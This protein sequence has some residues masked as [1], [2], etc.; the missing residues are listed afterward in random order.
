MGATLQTVTNI[1]KEVYSGDI[2][3]Q[4]NDD[5]T[6][7]KRIKSTSQGVTN[8]VGGRY[9]VF[10]IRTRRNQGIGARN[11]NE[12][13]PAAGQQGTAAGRVGLKYL[14][15]SIQLTGQVISLADSNYQSFASALDEEVT[16]V[17]NDVSKD[18][19]RQFY[20]D[21][22]GTLA[23]ITADGANTVTVA[24][25]QYLEEG[26]QIDIIDGTTLAAATPT[27]KASNRQITA[28]NQT[29]KVV[30]YSGADATAVANDVLVRTGNANREMTG[31]KAIIKNSGTLYN[32]DPTVEPVW[33]ANVLDN[34][35]TPR[36]LSEALMVQAVDAVR[37]KGS[38]VTVGFTSLGV[39][40][41][42][43][44]LL[45]QERRMVNTTKFEG[46]FEGL[47]FTTDQGD[48]PIV[49]DVDA[50]YGEIQFVN[51]KEIKLYQESEWGFMD[52]DGSMWQRVVGFDA[53]AATLYKYAEMGTRRRNAHAKLADITEG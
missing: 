42:Y 46:G 52:R 22:T 39:R 23:V 4:L 7:L 41:A 25:T 1:L 3:N 15:G 44:N 35:G 29:T 9:V 30:T 34:A 6:G 14:Y 33:K 16:G 48:I 26:Q 5:I 32:I 13:L 24:S 20:G 27:V 18:T 43:F 12:A 45:R 11:E 37:L 36:A 31:L 21:G 53:Y 49:V 51:E 10:P 2:E 19:N 17:K 38:K 50:P 28:I 40:R 47:S 8:E